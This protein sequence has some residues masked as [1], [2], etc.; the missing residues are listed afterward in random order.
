MLAYILYLKDSPMERELARFVDRLEELRVDSK[1]VEADSREGIALS[2]EYDLVSRPSVALV[3]SD[4]S[5]IERWQ[6]ELPLV[7]DISYLAHQ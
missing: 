5:L 3:R 7:E 4:G 2:E 6:G 1:M